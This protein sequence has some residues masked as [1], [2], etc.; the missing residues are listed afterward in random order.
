MKRILISGLLVLLQACG[1]APVRE[2][3]PNVTSTPSGASVFA[4]GVKLGNTPLSV[5]LFKAF[6]TSWSGWQLSAT[7]VLSIRKP[8][9]EDFNL[10]VNDAVLSRPIHARLKCRKAAA[11]SRGRHMPVRHKKQLPP[12]PAKPSYSR[13]IE[14][15]LKELSRLHRKGV[16]TDEEYRATRQRILGEL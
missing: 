2:A 4:N 9:C 11:K 15:R 6:P 14:R 5:N 7:G 10:K 8:G 12:A 1:T 3:T 16:I 13:D